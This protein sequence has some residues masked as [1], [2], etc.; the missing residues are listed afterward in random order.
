MW[1]KSKV[2]A[3]IIAAS[4]ATI[5]NAHAQTAGDI[6]SMTPQK[7]LD[8]GLVFGS[9]LTYPPMYY[10]LEDGKT[11]KGMV[12][13]IAD[14]VS[15]RMGTKAIVEQMSL[16]AQVAAA[17]SGKIDVI[18]W[19]TDTEERRQDYL[20]V[21]FMNSGTSFLVAEGNPDKI[22]S[23]SDF[24]GR[25]VGASRGTPQV[26]Q[27]GAE[28]KKCTDAGKET[29]TLNQY[30]DTAAGEAALR[31]N[32]VVAY[33]AS[34]PGAA[35]KAQTI[36]DGKV[37][38]AIIDGGY[39]QPLGFGVLKGNEALA[40]ALTA[41]FQSMVDDGWLKNVMTNYGLGGSMREKIEI[42]AGAN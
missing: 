7:V 30:P 16:A 24:C 21:D 17:K 2:S 33:L 31:T 37:F 41:A 25:T 10:L 5:A 12:I 23:F 36:G 38:D 9:S 1:S 11:Q 27:A 42:N 19:F 35:Y 13:E 40:N 29:I 4:L 34:P 6:K 3:L 18:P 28:A 20:I 14:E 22:A 32:K 8:N 39:A 26:I 15:K